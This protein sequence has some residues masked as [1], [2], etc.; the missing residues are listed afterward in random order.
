MDIH[1]VAKAGVHKPGIERRPDGVWVVR[2]RERAID[3]KAN[4]AIL[5]SIAA[6]LDVP[7]SSLHL[8]RGQGSRNKVVRAPD[9]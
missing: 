2:V 4:Q 9:P 8:L 3:G 7:V 6:E 1:V 5:K